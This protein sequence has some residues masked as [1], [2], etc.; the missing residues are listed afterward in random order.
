MTATIV[1][2]QQGIGTDEPNKSAA[3]EIKSEKRGL[4]I[5]RVECKI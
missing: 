5:P 3:L 2:A 4:L 1:S